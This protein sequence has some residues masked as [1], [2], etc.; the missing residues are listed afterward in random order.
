MKEP[1]SNERVVK[2]AGIDLVGHLL[3][4]SPLPS[5]HNTESIDESWHP[6]QREGV[7][8][9]RCTIERLMRPMGLQGVVRG[10]TPRTTFSDRATP[11]HSGSRPSPILRRIVRRP[12]GSLTSPL[13]QLGRLGLCALRHQRLGPADRR[14]EGLPLARTGLRARRSRAGPVRTAARSS[15][16]WPDPHRDQGVRYVSIR[17]TDRRAEARME[18]A[19]DRGATPDD[20]ARAETLSG[21]HKAEGIHQPSWNNGEA[22]ERALSGGWTGTALADGSSRWERTARRS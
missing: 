10:K 3:C 1:T 17:S 6:L 9:A 19:V 14:Q 18:P 13:F 21:L 15:R 12:C 20:H 4:L 22:V 16:G 11:C 2:V 7:S 5:L 8:A